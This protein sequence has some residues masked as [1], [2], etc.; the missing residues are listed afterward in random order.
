MCVLKGMSGRGAGSQHLEICGQSRLA[1]ET[2]W[3]DSGFATDCLGPVDHG[4]KGN[5]KEVGMTL[6]GVSHRPC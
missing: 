3:A 4:L 1:G 5:H 6:L 2:A